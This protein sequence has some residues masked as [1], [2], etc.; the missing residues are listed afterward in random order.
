MQNELIWF[1]INKVQ[2]IL[3]ISSVI[4]IILQNSIV[5]LPII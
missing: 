1:S 2:F 5:I 3:E 4:I